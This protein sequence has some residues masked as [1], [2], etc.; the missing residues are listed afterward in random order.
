MTFKKTNNT[1]LPG[2]YT[3][4]VRHRRYSPKAHDFQYPLAMLMLDLGAVRETFA[5]SPF[6]SQERF[7]LISFKRKN[8]IQTAEGEEQS[9][10]LAVAE[11]IKKQTGESFS[12]RIVL[13]TH[14][15]YLGFVMNPVSFYFCYADNRLVHIVAEINNTPWDERFTY[16]LTPEPVDA[17]KPHT[18]SFDFDKKFHVSPFMP[19]DMQYQWRFSL[20]LDKI[21]IHMLLKQQDDTVFDATMQ[22]VQQEFTAKSML[23]LP[24][25]YPVQTVLVAVRIYW[26]AFL[27]YIK[28]VK[29]LNHPDKN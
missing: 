23:R 7:N 1:L 15:R 11:H 28:G 16:V 14:P 9:I 27:L 3:G 19:M 10:T 20:H 21:N 17:L 4:W 8:Y 5:K 25:V 13:L 29:F 26:N 2:I 18:V 22:A 12:G 6:W 24:L